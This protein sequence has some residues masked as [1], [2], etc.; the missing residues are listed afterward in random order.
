M[1]AVPGEV[2]V[3]LPSPLLLE[4]DSDLSASPMPVTVALYWITCCGY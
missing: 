3:T 2:L 4:G 1:A